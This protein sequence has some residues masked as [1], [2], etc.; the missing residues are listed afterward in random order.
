MI[1]KRILL[2]FIFV[3]ILSLT[4]VYSQTLQ[5]LLNK[6]RQSGLTDEQIKQQA[7]AMGYNV[8][9]YLNF[10]QSQ[11]LSASRLPELHVSF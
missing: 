11:Q 7:A 6:A 10:Q 1:P 2:S 8:S 4:L 5:D 3:F 9:D